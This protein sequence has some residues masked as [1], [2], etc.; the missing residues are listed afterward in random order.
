[1]RAR[2]DIEFHVR[3]IALPHPGDWRQ[4]CIQI[5]RIH[6]RPLD[7]SKPLW[8]MYVIEG[9]DNVE[10]TPKNSFAV[11]TKIHHSAI[12]GVS[13]AELTAVIHDIEPDAIP[14]PPTEQWIPE[15]DPSLLELG[16]RTAV[17]NIQEPFRFL[18]VMSRTIPSI[19]NVMRSDPR[20]EVENSSSVP[21]K[22]PSV[23]PS[24][25]ARPSI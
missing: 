18:R 12:D 5:A 25:T 21:R 16:M 14:E 11:M 4:L 3:H 2:F 8:E 1:M 20:E 19:A 22:S 13:G 10:G 17:R 24:S 6:A 23:I 15:E 9:L 7:L